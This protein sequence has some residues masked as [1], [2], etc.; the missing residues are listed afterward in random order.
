[1]PDSTTD[2]VNQMHFYGFSPAC[3]VHMLGSDPVKAMQWCV[4]QNPRV[5]LHWVYAADIMGASEKVA[6]KLRDSGA[7]D[8]EYVVVH[9]GDVDPS[10]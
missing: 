4:A 2:P 1:M 8:V 9:C 6:Q 10:E 7:D 5:V 3:T